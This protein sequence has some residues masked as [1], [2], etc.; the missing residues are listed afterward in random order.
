MVNSQVAAALTSAEDGRDLE[1]A[2][3]WSAGCGTLVCSPLV[4]AEKEWRDAAMS[5]LAK[6]DFKAAN[7]LVEAA[8][9]G[10][11]ARRKVRGRCERCERCDN[12]AVTDSSHSRRF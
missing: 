7:K 1:E 9:E 10:Q 4:P 11:K 5:S 12:E 3:F 6:N 8:E 2:M